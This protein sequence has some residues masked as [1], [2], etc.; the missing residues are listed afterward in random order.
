MACSCCG[1]AVKRYWPTNTFEPLTWDN[2]PSIAPEEYLAGLWRWSETPW[3]PPRQTSTSHTS[4]VPSQPRMST[5]ANTSSFLFEVSVRHGRRSDAPTWAIPIFY[6][7]SVGDLISQMVE[8]TGHAA[9]DILLAGPRGT[10]LRDHS[11]LICHMLTSGTYLI[12]RTKEICRDFS[13]TGKPCPRGTR[14]WYAH[15]FPSECAWC[16]TNHE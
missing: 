16:Q 8:L 12:A 1:A 11:T 4:F 9:E 7:T 2:I 15:H 10:F 6:H 3:T 5:E 14:C 13:I